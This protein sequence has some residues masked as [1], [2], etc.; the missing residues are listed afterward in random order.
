MLTGV[1]KGVRSAARANSTPEVPISRST[2]IR[3]MAA[4]PDKQFRATR[5]RTP[6]LTPDQEEQVVTFLKKRRELGQGLDYRHASN[7]FQEIFVRLRIRL[8]HRDWI[9]RFMARHGL[10]HRRGGKEAKK[11]AEI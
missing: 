11:T 8:P 7:L 9:Y 5:G 3:Y 2:L 6:L 4:P 1:H 10:M